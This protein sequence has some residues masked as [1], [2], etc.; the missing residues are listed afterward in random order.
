MATR[1]ELGLCVEHPVVAVDEY[2]I[3]QGLRGE[4]RLDRAGEREVG[5]GIATIKQS[6]AAAV[7]KLDIVK[8]PADINFRCANQLTAAD[9]QGRAAGTRCEN[10]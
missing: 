6:N 9:V 3:Q 2:L 8:G 4:R 10:E 5:S 1:S 7:E